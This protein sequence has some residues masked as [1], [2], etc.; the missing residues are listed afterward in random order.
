MQRMCAGRG[1]PQKSGESEA[2]HNLVSCAIVLRFPRVV[3]QRYFVWWTNATSTFVSPPISEQNLASSQYQSDTHALR[4]LEKLGFPQ[5]SP[6]PAWCLRN[7]ISR[8]TS[9]GVLPRMD[10]L[11][12][13]LCGREVGRQGRH[14]VTWHVGNC[15]RLF[16]PDFR[17]I[18][19]EGAP[20]HHTTRVNRWAR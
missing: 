8:G 19:V 9:Q 14:S 13:V 17:R 7:L 15:W 10:S 18:G 5:L 4:R 11:D 1:C 2:L 12:T 16:A 6:G 20:V 3:D